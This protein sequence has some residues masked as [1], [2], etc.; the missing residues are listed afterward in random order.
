M[1]CQADPPGTASCS[2]VLTFLA[3]WECGQGLGTAVYKLLASGSYLLPENCSQENS[4][5]LKQKVRWKLAVTRIRSVYGQTNAA[6][7]TAGLLWRAWG[8]SLH[9][10]HPQSL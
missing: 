8:P 1:G 6:W 3:I 7:S 2:L 10:R 9:T 5:L 4:A